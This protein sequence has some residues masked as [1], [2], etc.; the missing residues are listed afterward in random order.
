[1]PRTARRDR[2]MSD[3]NTAGLYDASL[4]LAMS[5]LVIPVVLACGIFEV[6]PAPTPVPATPI[7][8]TSPP[9]AFGSSALHEAIGKD[10]SKMVQVLVEAGADVNARN[11]Y[12]DL[13]PHRSDQEG[14]R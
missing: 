3:R 1:M 13:A 11:R 10:D 2:A 9:S 6:D 7:A 5:I 14:Q 8:T 4:I 12:G